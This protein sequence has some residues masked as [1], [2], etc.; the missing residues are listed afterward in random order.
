MN[1]SEAVL[2]LGKVEILGEQNWL[3][4]HLWIEL[5]APNEKELCGVC[6]DSIVVKQRKMG[7][8]NE[9]SEAAQGTHRPIDCEW[10]KDDAGHGKVDSEQIAQRGSQC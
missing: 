10:W 1:E 6:T 2:W 5:V 9:C 7:T 3:T 8:A 4:D